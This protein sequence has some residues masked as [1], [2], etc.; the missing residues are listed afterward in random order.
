MHPSQR[1]CRINGRTTALLHFGNLCYDSLPILITMN[2]LRGLDWSSKPT[3]KPTQSNYSAFNTLKPTPPGSGRVS[4]LP[5]S[6]TSNPPSKPGTPANDTF[7]NL[8]SFSSSSANKNL[9]LQEQSKRLADLKLQQQGGTTRTTHS[10]YAAVDDSVWSNLGSGRSTPANAPTKPQTSQQDQDEDDLFAVFNAPK[11]APVKPPQPSK[12]QAIV[13]DDDDPFGLSEFQARSTRNT[14]SQPQNTRSIE[15]SID[16]DDVLGLLGRPV[17]EFTPKKQG[18]PEPRPAAKQAHPQ[19]QAVAELVD[20]GFPAEKARQALETTESGVDVQAAVGWLLNQAHAEAQAKSK[21]IS[22]NSNNNESRQGRQRPGRDETIATPQRERASTPSNDPAQVA[23]ELGATFLKT[24]GSLWKQSQ[25]RLQQAVQEFNSDSESSQPKW[26]RD[27][28]PAAR[29]SQP[30]RRKNGFSDDRN[31]HEGSPVQRQ[32]V[33]ATDEALMLEAQRPEKPPRPSRK[34]QSEAMF[35]SSR[36]ASRDHSPVMPSRL[37]E[38]HSP[39]P[40]QPIPQRPR[41]QMPPSR[42]TLNRQAAEDQAAQAYVSSARRRKPAAPISAEPELLEGASTIPGPAPS[43]SR[44]SQSVQ[45]TTRQRPV[46]T[47]P[48]QVRPPAPTRN[49]PS[50]SAI[51]LKASHVDREAGNEHFKRGD[52]SAAHQSYTKSLSHLPA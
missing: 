37:R 3:T 9:S 6:A 30:Q 20:M 39:Q 24:A 32:E 50:V 40:P 29:P 42:A 16:D 43:I 38:S 48:V 11:A 5:P 27:S 33:S 44:S 46:K 19:D 18:S 31:R 25:K 52:Y 14:T 21:S 26:M 35:D 23:G 17:T 4:P 8:V 41:Q 22:G 36:D 47:T 49:I 7:A 1:V 2:D 45:S 28:S 34:L 10:Q 12:A 51:T 13:D 15:D